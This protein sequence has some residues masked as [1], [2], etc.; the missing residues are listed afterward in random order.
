MTVDLRQSPLHDAGDRLAR[1]PVSVVEQ[2]FLT[3]L[4]LRCDPR[5][6]AR[7]AVEAVLGAPLPLVPCT[8]TALADGE[9]LWLGPDEWLVVL[10]AG[11]G[12]DLM[13][14]LAGEG[15]GL[16]DVSAQRT[17]VRLTGPGVAELL[18]Q[19]CAIDLHPRVTPAGSCLQTLLAQTGVLLVIHDDTASDVLVLVRSSYAQYLAS[20]LIDAS[21]GLGDPA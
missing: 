4:N 18:A 14:A 7:A 12:T 1:L 6:P 17:A 8:T 21:G 5:G 10:R 20:W 13:T 19:G 15:V 9:V 3:Q 16:T 11:S 2:P